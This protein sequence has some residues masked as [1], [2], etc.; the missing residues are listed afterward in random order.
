MVVATEDNSVAPRRNSLLVN[1]NLTTPNT[2]EGTYVTGC[3][4]PGKEVMTEEHSMF[5]LGLPTHSTSQNMA[6]ATEAT[7]PDNI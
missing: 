6:D 7:M 2:I 1:M 4:V 5:D 3:V